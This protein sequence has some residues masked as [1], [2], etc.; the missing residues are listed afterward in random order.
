MLAASITCPR[1]AAP[2]DGAA[3]FCTQCGGALGEAAVAPVNPFY[4]IGCHTCGGDG[5]RLAADKVYCPTCRWLRP[6][7]PGYDMPIE[8]FMWRFDAEA[9]RVLQSIG[10]LN[11]AAHALSERVGRPWFEASVNGLRL[12]EQQLPDIFAHAIRAARIVG[13]PYLPEIYISGEHMWDAVTMGSNSSAF[14][15][16]GSVLTMFRGDDLLYVIGR[17]MGHAKAGHA[18]WRTVVN[19]MA[20]RQPANRS[21]MSDGVLSYLNPAKFIESGINAPLMAWQRHAEITADRAGLLV[22]GKPEVARRVT[23]QSTL[24]S[25]PLYQQINQQAWMEQEDASDDTAMQASEFAMTATPYAA[26]RLKLMREFAV[27]EELLA[28]RR[29]IDHWQSLEPKPPPVVATP[30]PAPAPKRAPAAPPPD[31]TRLV[32]IACKTPMRVPRASLAGDKPVAVRCPNP[33]CGKVL[34]ITP[35]KPKPPKPEVTSE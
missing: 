21:L 7:G 9:M 30:A 1:C 17:E 29:V 27:S 3:R 22:V 20:G 14:I 33:A 19:L 4:S 6:L 24:H 5:S 31:T 26:R 11:A 34:S 23:L 13:L 15:A 18:L 12:S 32:C 25:F 35:K 16:I 8:A 28:W 2:S 10:P